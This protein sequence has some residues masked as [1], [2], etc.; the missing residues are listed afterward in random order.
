M[1]IFVAR[2]PIFDR[3]QRI[4]GYEL[5][6]RTGMENFFN[7]VNLDDATLAVIRNVMLVLGSEYLSGGNKVFVNFTKSL[8]LS[9]APAFLPKNSSVIEILENVE[10]DEELLAACRELRKQGYQLALDDFIWEVN[11]PNP[12]TEV[13]HFIKVDFR[14]TLPHDR[15]A[16]A[17]FFNAKDVELLA[18]KT[19][20]RRE[21]QEALAMGFSYF[22]GYFFSKPEIISGRDIPGY[23][24]HYLRILQEV[25][26]DQL[27]FK[28]LQAIIEQDP[29]LCLKIL[30]YL[31][32]AFFALRY[33]I[34]SIGHAL[35]LLGEK[36]IRKWASLAILVHLGKDQPTELMRLSIL[37]AKF[38]ESLAPKFGLS[39][40]ESKLFLMGLLSLM[41][42]F[43]ERPLDEVLENIPLAKEI[44][45]ALQGQENIHR[46]VLDL[47]VYYE[48]GAW[49]S[50]S[51]L[52]SQLNLDESDLPEIYARV[53]EFV[54][55]IPLA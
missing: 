42:V 39:S 55:S 27:D 3:Q 44:K 51:Q 34:T 11:E 28:K 8:L 43:W 37:R 25:C 54:E 46:R 30:T 35:A 23:K 7:G 22:Q 20:T 41:D 19:E 6:Y 48:K 50:V 13:V 45:Q 16:M 32:S 10:V 4:Y 1:D 9:D 49:E 18:E 12:L 24:L 52:L 2:Q 33:E 14:N 21:F 26:Q 5:L 40:H 53:I 31:N 29:P 17:E 47:V 15:K 38:C 36:E